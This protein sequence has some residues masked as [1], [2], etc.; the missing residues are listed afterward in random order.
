MRIEFVKLSATGNDFI[1]I[2]NRANNIHINADQCKRICQRKTGIGADGIILLEKSEQAD[3]SMKYFNADGSEG[4]M[5]GNGGRAITFFAHYLGINQR[6]YRIQTVNDIYQSSF[7]K[8][9]MIELQMSELYD[10][11][12]YD[13]SI[14]PEFQVGLYLNT[15]VPHVVFQVANLQ[16]FDAFGTGRRIRYHSLFPNGTNVNFFEIKKQGIV[17]VRTYERGVEDETLSCGTGATAVAIACQQLFN[18]SF[19]VE[20]HA[21]GGIL[22]ILKKDGRY[23]LRGS[24]DKV[25]TGYLEIA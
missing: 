9:G 18:W 10:V 23:Y 22:Q 24:V 16:N 3:F 21:P 11:G 17:S 14:F 13:L 1:A 12:K 2:D 8:D 15:G 20:I 7:G 4:E 25:F 6:P 5:C 19:P